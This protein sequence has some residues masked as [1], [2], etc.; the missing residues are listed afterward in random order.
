MMSSN[1]DSPSRLRGNRKTL[2][3]TAVDPSA[4]LTWLDPTVR[5]DMRWEHVRRLY[6]IAP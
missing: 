5:C 3:D 4:Y 1:F 2:L 6:G